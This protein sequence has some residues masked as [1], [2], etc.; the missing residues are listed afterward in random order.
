MFIE[1]GQNCTPEIAH[2][3]DA[4]MRSRAFLLFQA[5]SGWN[6]VIILAYGLQGER[7]RACGEAV[8]GD[9]WGEDPTCYL[10]D[11]EIAP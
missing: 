11:E 9:C 3:N 8:T 7:C 4:K 5:A 6:Y 10:T 1:V 2:K